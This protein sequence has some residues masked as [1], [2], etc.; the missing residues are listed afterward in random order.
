[1]KDLCVCILAHNE[2]CNIASTVRSI[3]DSC[4][5]LHAETKVYANG[6]TDATASIVQEMTREIPNLT[7]RELDIASK[8]NAWNIAFCEN[9]HDALV[10]SD[11][12]VVPANKAVETLYEVLTKEGQNIILAGC[13]YWPSWKG[14]SLEQRWTGFLQIPLNQD[15]LAGA[16]YGIRKKEFKALL[17][18]Y[19]LSGIPGGLVGEDFFLEKIVPPDQFKVIRN[20]VYYAPPSWHDYCN[21]LAR[22]QWQEEQLK[23]FYGHLLCDYAKGGGGRIKRFFKKISNP[24]GVNNFPLGLIS[25][26][27][28]EGVKLLFRSKINQCYAA[29]GAINENGVDVLREATRSRSTK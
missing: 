23:E 12:D 3:S 29:L 24:R 16:L 14:K 15:F 13:R 18:H 20:K 9:N 27:M 8:P 6:C 25:S 10:F 19:R 5:G 21:Y 22:M 2:E 17:D 7:L 26:G 1:M 11:G 4:K 28:R